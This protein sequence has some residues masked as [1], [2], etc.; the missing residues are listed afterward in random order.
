MKKTN[1]SGTA[2]RHAEKGES[3]INNVKTLRKNAGMTQRQFAEYFGVPLATLRKWELP[4]TSTQH[5]RIQSYWVLVFEN[6]EERDEAVKGHYLIAPLKAEEAYYFIGRPGSR[7]Y[8][9]VCRN[10]EEACRNAC[11]W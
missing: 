2:E 11:A 4:A 3:H 1:A 8:E 9:E 6:K 10:A 5:R 7:L